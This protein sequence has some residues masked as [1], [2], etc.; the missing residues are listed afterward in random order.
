MTSA[1]LMVE[2]RE[3]TSLI[4]MTRILHVC[5]QLY[6]TVSDITKTFFYDIDSLLAPC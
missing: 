5:Y 1:V 2:E 3:N 6:L 4:I